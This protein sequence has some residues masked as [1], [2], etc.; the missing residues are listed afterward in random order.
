ME[1]HELISF[2]FKDIHTKENIELVDCPTQKMIYDYFIKPAQGSLW[3]NTRNIIM[4]LAPFPTEDC[5]EGNVEMINGI[6]IKMTC[7]FAD[8]VG[9]GR[10]V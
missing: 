5:V 3:G 9:T 8:I 4:C 6:G 2:F 7:K 1:Y 10:M